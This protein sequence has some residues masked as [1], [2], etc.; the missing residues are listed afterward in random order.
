MPLFSTIT[1]LLLASCGGE[2]GAVA[3]ASP[4]DDYGQ[5][6]CREYLKYICTCHKFNDKARC[7]NLKVQ[8]IKGHKYMDMECG[9]ELAA[10]K[11]VDKARRKSCR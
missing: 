5:G 1:F 4:W 8:L 7:A 9:Q 2:E 6:Q 11:R 3:K 10:Q